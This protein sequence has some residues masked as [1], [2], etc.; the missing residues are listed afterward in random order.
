MPPLLPGDCV[1][2]QNQTGN[3]PRQWSQTGVVI[4]AGPHNSY[5]VSVDGSRTITKRNRQFL[6]KISPFLHSTIPPRPAQIPVRPVDISLPPKPVPQDTP[7]K[8]DDSLNPAVDDDPSKPEPTETPTPNLPTDSHEPPIPK[9]I[10]KKK[11]LPPHLRERWIVASNPPQS[12]QHPDGSSSV[13]PIHHSPYMTNQYQPS[14]I[15][16]DQWINNQ[17]Q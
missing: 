3:Q 11:A 5:T 15:A 17:Y 2:I 1:A 7:S 13:T 6:R 12:Y 8:D 10:L 9:L 16:Y 4:E 14:V